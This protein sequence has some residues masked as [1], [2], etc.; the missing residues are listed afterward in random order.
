M[1]AAAEHQDP[2]SLRRASGSRYGRAAWN[3]FPRASWEPPRLA[4]N[5]AWKATAERGEATDSIAQI[6]LSVVGH[7]ESTAGKRMQDAGCDEQGKHSHSLPCPDIL[8]PW[9]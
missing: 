8:H 7:A 1:S 3:N 2:V 5:N 4:R 9:C 6:F